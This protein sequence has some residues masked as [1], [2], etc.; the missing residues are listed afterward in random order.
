MLAFPQRMQSISWL[1]MLF[2]AAATFGLPNSMAI[3]HLETVNQPRN[4]IA[5]P[6]LTLGLQSRSEAHNNKDTTLKSV[7]ELDPLEKS[8]LENNLLKLA[9][10][11]L[12]SGR[13][14]EDLNK[15]KELFDFGGDDKQLFGNGN[16]NGG[17]LG[18][19]FD[20]LSGRRKIRRFRNF[21]RRNGNRFL[22]ATS[23]GASI[24]ALSTAIAVSSAAAHTAH[25]HNHEVLLNDDFILEPVYH[26]S[27]SSNIDTSSLP[28]YPL[29]S[30]PHHDSLRQAAA[31]RELN[32]EAQQFLAPSELSSG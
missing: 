16:N 15:L 31:N 26:Q 32:T 7:K 1:F 29:P 25:N 23:I 4:V 12:F 14:E 9:F 8:L 19:L 6:F 17:L 28:I 13:S 22:H 10:E 18:N 11:K 3:T 27:R 5:D 21:F 24:A 2:L 20:I 30:F